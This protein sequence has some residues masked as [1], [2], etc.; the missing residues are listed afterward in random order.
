MLSVPSQ[1]NKHL[2]TVFIES[3]PVENELGKLR[4]ISNATSYQTSV[5]NSESEYTLSTFFT[6][7]LCVY[8]G[9]WSSTLTPGSP[10]TTLQLPA[11]LFHK[12]ISPQYNLL[13]SLTFYRA[14]LKIR[15]QVNGTKFHAGMLIGSFI[16]LNRL[17][18]D[19]TYF[20]GPS[21]TGY[22]NVKN[23]ANSNN[24]TEM[25]IPYQHMRDFLNSYTNKTGDFLGNFYLA[26]LNQ[27]MPSDTASPSIP[28][29][30]WVSAVAPELHNIVPDH[31][32]PYF[33]PTSG[34][35]ALTSTIS[36]VAG[37]VSGVVSNL[38]QGKIPNAIVGA[39]KTVSS[40]GSFFGGRDYPVNAAVDDK[41]LSLSN[42]VVAHGAGIRQST[43]LDLNPMYEHIPDTSHTATTTD[44][45][46]LSLVIQT[47][48]L[49]SQVTWNTTATPGT[50]L[51]RLIV[52]P[53]YCYGST[54]ADDQYIVQPT[55]LSYVAAVFAKWRGPL[56]YHLQI[57]KNDFQNGRLLIT[58]LPYIVP[59]DATFTVEQLTVPSS[60]A[61]DV[62]EFQDIT[63]QTPWNSDIRQKWVM[64][65]EERP[66]PGFRFTTY[67]WPMDYNMNNSAG[68]LL[69]SVLN[70]LNQSPGAPDNCTINVY[71]SG[72][73][74]TKFEVPRVPLTYQFPTAPTDVPTPA[75]TTKSEDDDKTWTFTSSEEHVEFDESRSAGA[76]KVADTVLQ[77]GETM[78][79]A[80]P[81]KIAR[82]LNM[83]L[84]SLLA[85]SYPHYYFRF[86]APA[87]NSLCIL[88]IPVRPLSASNI[89]VTG[90][91]P[92]LI[93]YFSGLY[94]FY[95]GS[96][97]YTIFTNT[98]KNT[99]GFYTICHQ[100]DYFE[101][102][103]SASYT[104]TPN[105]LTSTTA[106]ATQLFIPSHQHFSSV[107]TPYQSVY[108][109]LL[110]NNPLNDDRTITDNGTLQLTYYNTDNQLHDLRLPIYRAIGEGFR[111]SYLLPPAVIFFPLS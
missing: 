16:P 47:P 102:T 100:P 38:A 82:D 110:T 78:P 6:K 70:T 32:L 14:A 68:T 28:V 64:L 111:F 48:Q 62:E 12:A 75:P 22:P 53:L 88:Y 51:E 94:A 10:L 67:D 23:R 52:H 3:R 54:N 57:I 4:G 55:F 72:T 63:Y 79:H 30:V 27:L 83:H 43:V 97:A 76:A 109:N 93:S 74:E 61:L 35:E 24:V 73:P 69:I 59:A 101:T 96:F 95:T 66:T 107:V 108:T 1:T 25:I 65:D 80:D 89:D 21:L 104:V 18:P 7:E 20:A 90:Q 105:D 84:S 37:N 9:S 17:V 77:T 85:R 11:I 39:G 92:D 8:N 56:Q 19:G 98:T 31:E 50:I 26:V 45:M 60:I 58:Y 41:Q 5:S 2:N 44:E 87:A 99:S 13:R 81:A 29:S 33:T 103:P 42:P 40:I 34:L 71:I 36:S 91:T 106:Y 15:V 46:D 49:I 86:T